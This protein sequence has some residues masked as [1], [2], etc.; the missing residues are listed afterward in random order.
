MGVPVYEGEKVE[1]E[2]DGSGVTKILAIYGS[3]Y[4]EAALYQEKLK[5]CHFVIDGDIMTYANQTAYSKAIS[6]L[7]KTV[8]IFQDQTDGNTFYMHVYQEKIDI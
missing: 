5:D 7:L 8:I 6:E 3:N 2:Y 1:F 4:K